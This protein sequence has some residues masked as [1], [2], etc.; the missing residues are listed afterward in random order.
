MLKHAT[1]RRFSFHKWGLTSFRNVIHDFGPR[2]DWSCNPMDTGETRPLNGTPFSTGIYFAD[3]RNAYWQ[4]GDPTRELAEQMNAW[5]E[6]CPVLIWQSKQPVPPRMKHSTQESAA[7]NLVGALPSRFRRSRPNHR[8]YPQI[9][10]RTVRHPE[11]H[12]HRQLADC[13]IWASTR[14][15]RCSRVQVRRAPGGWTPSKNSIGASRGSC[16]AASSSN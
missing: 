16:P 3:L 13:G 14:R 10:C 1:C 15:D 6:D 8:Q 5:I 7:P 4:P 2:I 11:M 12:R 9:S